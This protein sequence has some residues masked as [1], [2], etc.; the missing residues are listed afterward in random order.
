MLSSGEL[1]AEFPFDILRRHPR[2]LHRSVDVCNSAR[3]FYSGEVRLRCRTCAH[4]GTLTRAL[5]LQSQAGSA[6]N[7]F[8]STALWRGARVCSSR[9]RPD[10]EPH[11]ERH[12]RQDRWRQ[13]DGK[14]VEQLLLSAL[15]EVCNGCSVYRERLLQSYI[16]SR[17]GHRSQKQNARVVVTGERI[18][19]TA[20]FL[21]SHILILQLA[22]VAFFVV[23]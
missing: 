5:S 19:I 12:D 15:D 22:H 2:C 11:D 17:H 20:Y 9:A 8:V 3:C 14:D 1:A 18:R 7:D 13:Q 23:I 6:R 21:S 10:R 16:V 4:N